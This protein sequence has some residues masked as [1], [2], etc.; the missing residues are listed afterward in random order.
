MALLA[1]PW[2]WTSE[3]EFKTARKFDLPTGLVATMPRPEV[4][5]RVETPNGALTVVTTVRTWI[6]PVGRQ[7]GKIELPKAALPGLPPVPFRAIVT[8]R[9][10]TEEEVAKLHVHGPYV[11]GE[12]GAGIRFEAPLVVVDE[13]GD[14]APIGIPSAFARALAP[15]DVKRTWWVTLGDRAPYPTVLRLFASDSYQYTPRVWIP[16]PRGFLGASEENVRVALAPGWITGVS[17]HAIVGDRFDWVPFAPGG[18]ATAFSGGSIGLGTFGSNRFRVARYAPLPLAMAYLGAYLAEGAKAGTGWSFAGVFLPYLCEVLD[19]LE[20]MGIERDRLAVEVRRTWDMQDQVAAQTVAVALRLPVADHNG[21]GHG[22][23]PCATAVY[24]PDSDGQLSAN[25]L[26]REALPFREATLAAISWVLA[27]V[28]AIPRAAC[29]AFADGYL[30]GD[31][32][33]HGAAEIG[34]GSWPTL[35]LA[36]PEPE[37][38]AVARVVDRAYGW[39]DRPW[40]YN[41]TSLITPLNE[42]RALDLLRCGVLRHSASRAR[43]LD[44]LRQLGGG[45]AAEFAAEIHDVDRAVGG[46]WALTRPGSATPGRKCV[47]FPTGMRS[48]ADIEATSFKHYRPYRDSEEELAL[49]ERAFA[50]YRERGFPYPGSDDAL[51]SFEAAQ[52]GKRKAW[53]LEGTILQAP[54]RGVRLVT[55]FH[56][57]LWDVRC[58]THMTPLEAWGDDAALRR[59]LRYCIQ[60]KDGLDP[61][62]VRDAVATLVAR[63]A[64]VMRPG[65]AKA[66]Y[67]VLKPGRVVDPCTGWGS[68]LFAALVASVPYVGLDASVEIQRGNGQLL[69][70]TRRVVPALSSA[71]ALVVGMAEETLGTGVLGGADM[72]FTSPPYHDKE[73]Y[74]GDTT[75]SY[76]RYPTWD[77]W[78]AGFLRPL[79]AGAWREV[80]RGGH[81]VL[82][83]RVGMEA[84][85]RE[86][87]QA[88]G[89]TEANVWTMLTPR[90]HFNHTRDLA[91]RGDPILVFRKP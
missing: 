36:G 86:A 72:V 20:A 84:A 65:I 50:H 5:V 46:D 89:L 56:P 79:L 34:P 30:S 81:V 68:R 8:L 41:V 26:L 62:S 45:G 18:H 53:R 38:R 76:V 64:S 74:V 1:I 61:R 29:Q 12:D 59:A 17:D 55:S 33:V 48:A 23:W 10:T 69:A 75:Q 9:E 32:T 57:E 60:M 16:A 15:D 27:N 31:G 28:D 3:V 80:D 40:H 51:L 44:V 13:R 21:A 39:I 73:R 37:V 7:R 78:V 14:I 25:L 63:K 58:D 24:S 70:A 83:I 47:A 90:Q 88:A 66:I 67:D 52:L 71:A 6:P 11:V 22:V 85:T 49:I 77:L 19:W 42:D 82:S 54:A 87:A 2:P 43:L 35:A 4:V 91:S